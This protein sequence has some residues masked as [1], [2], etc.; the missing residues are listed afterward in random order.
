VTPAQWRLADRVLAELDR[1]IGLEG[2][3]LGRRLNVTVA[4]LRPVI[5]VLFRRDKVTRCWGYI[6]AVPRQKKPAG[7]E[8]A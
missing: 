4:E 6:C 8:V 5:G 3:D 7:S 2:D 1:E